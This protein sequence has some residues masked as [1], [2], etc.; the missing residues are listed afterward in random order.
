MRSYNTVVLRDRDIEIFSQLLSNPAYSDPSNKKKHIQNLTNGLIKNNAI[1]GTKSSKL[2]LYILGILIL[3]V[4]FGGDDQEP[5]YSSG[6]HIAYTATVT[7]RSLRV[8]SAPTLNSDVINELN[9]GDVVEIQRTEGDW[10]FVSVGSLEGWVS[11][12]Y[13]STK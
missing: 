13:L 10:S 1:S 11:N 5:T 8:R 3:M 6:N 12:T 2:L 4:I 7:A 9:R